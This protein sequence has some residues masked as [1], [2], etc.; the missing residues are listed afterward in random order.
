MNSEFKINGL[1]LE[2]DRLILRAFQKSDLNHFFT[3]ASVEG[4]GEMAGW[5]HHET[6]EETQKILDMFIKNDNVF[7]LCLKENN[8]VIG[9]LG[10]ET[11]GMEEELS[12]F[13]SYQGRELGYVLSKDYWGRGLIP[14]AC[15]KVISYLFDELSLDFLLCGYYC[16]NKRSQRVQE[17]LGFVP[18]RKLMM[19]TRMGTQ[20]EGYLNLLI[21]PHKQLEL[22]F[23]HPETLIYNK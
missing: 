13:F 10:I 21:N 1:V 22:K 9:S 18:Y 5:K 4:V 11:Y 2:T 3:Y 12:E 8:Q 6:K 15:S 14:E 20:E 16:F 23:S 7:A 19:N 17:K